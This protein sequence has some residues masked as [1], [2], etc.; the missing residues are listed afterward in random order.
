ML[1]AEEKEI[2][3]VVITGNTCNPC[4]SKAG[5]CSEQMFRKEDIMDKFNSY[6]ICLNTNIV[7]QGVR[8][9]ER[10]LN[11]DHSNISKN[12]RGIRKSVNGLQFQYFNPLKHINFK[13]YDPSI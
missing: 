13:Y 10:V 4:E 6:I 7:Y 3:Q 5:H 12:C 1:Y 8:E 9:A 2:Q 11:I